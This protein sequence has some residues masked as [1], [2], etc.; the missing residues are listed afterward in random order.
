MFD[1]R[2]P[3]KTWVDAL[4][5]RAQIEGAGAF[6]LQQGDESRGDVL[7]KVADLNGAARAYVPRTSMEGTRVFVDLESQGIGPDEESVDAYVARAKAR[8]TDLWIVE[9]E[10]REARHFLT[11]PVE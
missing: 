1:E 5:R 6:V 2:L 11:E 8:D 4:L 9:I 3:T 10:D 7:I